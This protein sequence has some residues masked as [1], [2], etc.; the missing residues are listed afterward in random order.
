[1]VYGLVLYEEYLQDE[2]GNL[3]VQ[4]GSHIPTVITVDMEGNGYSLV[5]Y[6][7]PR[8]G[9]LYAPDIRDK[10]PARYQGQA[11]DLNRYYDGH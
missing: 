8:D 4:S 6:W 2:A 11:L 3:E 10:F 7:I 9:D 5:E 1:M